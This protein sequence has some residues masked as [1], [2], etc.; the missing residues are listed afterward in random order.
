MPNNHLPFRIDVPILHGHMAKNDSK[1]KIFFAVCVSPKD[2]RSFRR[3]FLVSS[4]I[5]TDGIKKER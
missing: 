1:E 3:T 5:D 4:A 2:D